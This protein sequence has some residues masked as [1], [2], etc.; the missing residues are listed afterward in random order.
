[1]ALK[2]TIFKADIDISDMDRGYYESHAL[3]LA[4]HAS[5]T[6]ERMMIRVLAFALNAHEHLALTDNMASPEDP[7]LW[8]KDLTGVIDVWIEVGQPDEKRLLKACGRAG[9]VIVYCYANSA[10]IWWNALAPKVERAKNLT[11]VHVPESVALA[12]LAQRTMSFQLTIEG[13]TV[14]LTA[15]EQ[16]VEITP[17]LLRQ[18]GSG[19]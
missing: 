13:G 8:Q 11:V 14:W 16:T 5:E 1:M 15:G 18:S 3:T 17:V 7:A 6:D 4:R 9:Q 12:S 10:L 2:A 19:S